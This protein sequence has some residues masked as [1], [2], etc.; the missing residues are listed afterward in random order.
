MS[1]Y[2]LKLEIPGFGGGVASW[3][4]KVNTIESGGIGSGAMS[5]DCFT[6]NDDYASILS[7]GYTLVSSGGFID[8]TIAGYSFDKYL[9]YGEASYSV[10]HN[11]LELMVTPEF[12][13]LFPDSITFH[14]AGAIGP[15]GIYYN[16][17]ISVYYFD[18]DTWYT[19]YSEDTEPEI[20]YDTGE[21]V[22]P[23]VYN[24]GS[25][26]FKG[27]VIVYNTEMLS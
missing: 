27:F 19:L 7:D 17:H 23:L 22:L 21:L 13:G 26:G 20:E 11:V 15:E 3:M 18:Q 2:L 12:D 24:E 10:S 14:S 8:G 4:Q 5:E 25:E 9:D 16:P 6:L 1:I